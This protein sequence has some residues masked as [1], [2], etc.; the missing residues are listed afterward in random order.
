MSDEQDTAHDVAPP[1]AEVHSS[2]G[3]LQAA[4]VGLTDVGCQRSTNQDA[5][6]NLVGEFADR[7]NDLGLLYAV[8]DGMGGHARGEV[9]SALAIENLFARYYASDPSVD[10]RENLAQ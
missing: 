10:P 5:L 1:V 2:S 9:A 7:T 4:S 3:A 6:G 8:A